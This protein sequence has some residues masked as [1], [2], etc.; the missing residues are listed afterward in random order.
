MK[1]DWHDGAAASTIEQQPHT[2]RLRGISPCPSVMP[3]DHCRKLNQIHR[4][5]LLFSAEIE[6]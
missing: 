5:I 1:Y 2:Y 6:I 3:V 4:K